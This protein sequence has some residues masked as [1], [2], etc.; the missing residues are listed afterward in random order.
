MPLPTIRL[1]SKI[2]EADG[3]MSFRFEKPPGFEYTAGQFADYTE[4]QL[5]AFRAGERVNDPNRMMRAVADKMSDA[6]I[7][8]V[9]DY[10]AGL[11]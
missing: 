10:I 3:S 5:K 9:S 7:K 6:E 11:R 2:Q 1:Q 8:A 4:V